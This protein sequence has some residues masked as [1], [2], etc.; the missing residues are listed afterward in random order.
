MWRNHFTCDVLAEKGSAH[1]TSLCKWG[2]ASFIRRTRVLPAGRPC[3]TIET[4]TQD[5]PTWS[6]EYAHFCSLCERA[7][8]TDLS[9]DLW[10]H[11]VLS[12]LGG[13]AIARTV[14]S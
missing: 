9:N 12:R 7:A 1:I 13:E 2:P 10:L 14:P 5:D 8:P 3:E 4:L 11:R 6:A